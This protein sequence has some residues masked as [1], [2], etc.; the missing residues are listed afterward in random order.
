MQTEPDTVFIQQTHSLGLVSSMLVD[1]VDTVVVSD[2]ILVQNWKMFEEDKNRI[3]Y[4]LCELF[5]TPWPPDRIDVRIQLYAKSDSSV[6]KVIASIL[7]RDFVN[8]VS[9]KN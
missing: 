6:S 2:T 4:Q 5:G 1:L 9:L 7:S 8:K 3:K